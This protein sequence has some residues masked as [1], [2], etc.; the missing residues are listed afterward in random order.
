MDRFAADVDAIYRVKGRRHIVVSEGISDCE[1]KPIGATLIEER[2]GGWRT[3]TCSCRGRRS[4]V[5]S[6]A[7]S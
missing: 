4:W 1:G 5:I 6:S 3:A 2:A 7:T